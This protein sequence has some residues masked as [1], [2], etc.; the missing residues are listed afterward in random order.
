MKNIKTVVAAAGGISGLLVLVMA[1]FVWS[2]FSAKT[3]AIEGDDE[4]GT[5]GLETVVEKASSLSRK[6]VYPCAESVKAVEANSA[7]VEEW[8]KDAL[9]LASRGDKLF[10]SPSE[11]QFKSFLVADAR[12]IATLPGVVGGVLVK[13]EFT[14]GPFKDY[15]SGGAMPK[16]DD[17]PVLQR[18][19]DDIATIA[20]LLADSGIAELVDIKLLTAKQENAEEQ[21]N[22]R[23]KKKAKRGV[24]ESVE[25]APEFYTYQFTFTTRP[26]GFVKALNALETSQR[27]TIVDDFTFTRSRDAIADAIGG[28]KKEAAAAGRRG[29]RRGRR[30]A[31]EDEKEEEN[32]TKNGIITDPLLDEPFKVDM[33]ISVYDFRMAKAAPEA[34]DAAA[35]KTE[36]E[37]K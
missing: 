30:G 21:N 24:E 29:G 26:L 13:P 35:E 22:A 37:K 19:W 31:V 20:G 25:N 34:G 9:S 1:Y 32:S 36:E 5:D 11:A 14:F 18:Q 15:I 12:R 23:G 3:A 8:K 33:K 17:I 6:Q 28:E 16:K 10:D 4:E 27:F 2:A 7:M